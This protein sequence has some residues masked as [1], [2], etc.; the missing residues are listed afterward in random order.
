MSLNEILVKNE[1]STD[2]SIIV[3]GMKAIALQGGQ[4]LP[5]EVLDLEERLKNKSSFSQQRIQQVYEERKTIQWDDTRELYNRFDLEGYMETID[6]AENIDRADV[7]ETN[8]S[9]PGSHIPGLNLSLTPGELRQLILSKKDHSWVTMGTN[10]RNKFSEEKRCIR[11]DGKKV[12][13]YKTLVALKNFA[14]E[15]MYT[16]KMILAMIRE[17]ASLHYKDLSDYYDM[18][19]LDQLSQHLIAKDTLRY[20][21][22]VFIEPLTNFVRREGEDLSASL[23]TAIDLFKQS[24]DLADASFVENDANYNASLHQ[25]A[26]DSL[27]NLTS[28]QLSAE[29]REKVANS[30]LEGDLIDFGQL[31]TASICWEEK[32]GVPK[33]DLKLNWMSKNCSDTANSVKINNVT[34][35]SPEMSELSSSSS[36]SSDEDEKINRLMI[37]KKK[38]YKKGQKKTSLNSSRQNLSDS[39]SFE[40]TTSNENIDDLKILEDNKNVELD[41]IY[42]LAR[43]DY[44][45]IKKSSK[46]KHVREMIKN[47]FKEELEKKKLP[48]V[49]YVEIINRLK[50]KE[51]NSRTIAAIM[52]DKEV[53]DTLY[54]GRTNYESKHKVVTEGLFG[55]IKMPGTRN[56]DEVKINNV[57]F[58]KYNTNDGYLKREHEKNRD[59]PRREVSFD[60]NRDRKYTYDKNDDKN[61]RRNTDRGRDRYSRYRRNDSSDSRR[62][63][64]TDR[65]KSRSLSRNSFTDY[66]SRSQSSRDRSQS[67]DRRNRSNS[68]YR[69]NGRKYYLKSGRNTDE[70]FKRE[71]KKYYDDRRRSRDRW[72][73][74]RQRDRSIESQ[75]RKDRRRER[76]VSP[77]VKEVMRKGQNCDD[78]YSPRRKFCSKC[79]EKGHHPFNC[80][81]FREWRR[82]PCRLCKGHHSE[83]ECNERR[84][85]ILN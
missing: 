82:E 70:R 7:F 24:R 1:G 32:K 56:S 4:S 71:N 68:F 20:K 9:Y 72:G 49:I 46:F 81:K 57:E 8:N 21:K 23:N 31:L 61:Y 76:T 37:K 58:K 69:D 85:K 73:D 11:M 3:K 74:R 62:N 6:S 84:E 35:K 44:N 39:D 38:K 14:R 36:S 45:K 80:Q 40:S 13:W 75:T 33:K 2:F 42:E 78:D 63:Y 48:K 60:R 17:I 41:A 66:R 18:L 5:K 54:R 55:D 67:T 30:R 29:L 28:P 53:L 10:K 52:Y 26:I 12:Q 79:M 83:R 34:L 15:N 16:Q 77:G 59:K 27:I 22:Q 25:F 43:D 19:D 50:N 47:T 65:D 51:Y 64:S